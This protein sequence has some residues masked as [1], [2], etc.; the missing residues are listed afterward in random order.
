MVY[1]SGKCVVVTL[2][3]NIQEWD[4]SILFKFH[5]EFDVGMSAVEILEIWKRCLYCQ[6]GRKC[7]QR[8]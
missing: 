5:G 3:T 6:I 2:D 1:S 7:H 4:L 8:I